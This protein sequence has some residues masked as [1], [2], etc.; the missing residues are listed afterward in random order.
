MRR[1]P[2]STVP[3]STLQQDITQQR[4]IIK[5]G[6]LMPAVWAKRPGG[7]NGDTLRNSVYTCIQ[8]ASYN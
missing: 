8:E 2:L 6:E 7:N 3:A 5:P 4:Y 1:Y